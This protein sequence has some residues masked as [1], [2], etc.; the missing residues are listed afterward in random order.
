[1]TEKKRL[2]PCR[3]RFFIPAL[4]LALFSM[5]LVGC[6]PSVDHYYAVS[7]GP[8]PHLRFTIDCGKS[9]EVQIKMQSGVKMSISPPLLLENKY[10][11]VTISVEIPYGHTGHFVGDGAVIRIA[12][13]TEEWHGSLVGTFKPVWDP[14]ANQYIFVRAAFDPRAEMHGGP[15]SS[16]F[17]YDVRPDRPFPQVFSVQL[18]NFVVDGDEVPIPEVHFRW[19]SILA[20]CVI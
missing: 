5:G 2:L 6:F 20:M 7:V 11:F 14:K 16:A 13:S 12:D 19:G 18:P 15:V 9:G 3:V 10:E 8:A 1:M 4:A 17:D